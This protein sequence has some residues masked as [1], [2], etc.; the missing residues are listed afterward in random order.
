MWDRDHHRLEP[1]G[2]LCVPGQVPSLSGPVF[3]SVPRVSGQGSADSALACGFGVLL[4]RLFLFRQTLGPPG[5]MESQSRSQQGRQGPQ[6]T[7]P[8]PHRKQPKAELSPDPELPPLPSCS[9]PKGQKRRLTWL[10]TLPDPGAART[11]SHWG[12]LLRCPLPRLQSHLVSH[13]NFHGNWRVGLSAGDSDK[14]VLSHL[15]H[16]RG[17]GSSSL[18]HPTAAS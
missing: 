11:G 10:K 5:S 7:S 17:A 1:Q 13:C 15:L 2:L 6:T 4:G 12:G 14:E 18:A 9:L 8:R 3:P 16:R